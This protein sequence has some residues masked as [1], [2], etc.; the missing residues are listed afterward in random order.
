M[1]EALQIKQ[2]V[3][4]FA[5]VATNPGVGP[6]LVRCWS[7]VAPMWVKQAPGAQGLTGKKLYS[8]SFWVREPAH[9]REVRSLF[10]SRGH[11]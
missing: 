8:C 1:S 9:P 11:R 10:L 4:D 3:E 5:H 2:D 7:G 6:A